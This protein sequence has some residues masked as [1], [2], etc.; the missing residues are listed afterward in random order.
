MGCCTCEPPEKQTLA[1]ITPYEKRSCTDVLLL[2]LFIGFWI[3]TV[4][5][6][7]AAIANGGNPNRVVRGV[8]MYGRICGVS[9]GVKD[10]KYAAWP[11]PDE[12]EPKICVASCAETKT[13]NNIAFKHNSISFLYYCVPSLDGSVS[14]SV[15][16]DFASA[17]ERLTRAIG[18]CYTAWKVILGS[19]FLAIGLAFMYLV[20]VRLFSGIL[21]WSAIF[22]VIIGGAFLG[23][24]LLEEAKRID[25]EGVDTDRAKV[26]KAFGA[27]AIVFTVLFSL[28]VF[29]LRKRIQIAV[30]VVKEASQALGDMK[31]MILFPL[32]PLVVALAYVAAWI[33]VA[34]Y[35]YSVA[36]TVTKTTPSTVTSGTSNPSTYQF[37]ERNTSFNNSLIYHFFG[38]LWNVQFL[39]YFSYMVLA[40]AVADWYFTPKG[41]F[42]KIKKNAVAPLSSAVNA[43][44]DDNK[45]DKNV[46][47]A[48]AAAIGPVTRWPVASSLKRTLRFHLGTVA[49]GALIIAIINFIRAWV[50]YIEE[51]TKNKNNTIQKVFFCM[52]QCFLKC[53]HCCADKI[54]KNSFI[55]T[56]IWGDNFMSGA[57]GSFC[58]IWNNLARVA[59]INVVSAYLLFLGKVLVALG[60]TGISAIILVYGSEYKDDISSPILPLLIIFIISYAVSCLFMLVYDT[61]IDTIFLC[62]LVDEQYNKNGNMMASKNLQELIGKYSKESQ[63]LAVKSYEAI[64]QPQLNSP[65]KK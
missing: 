56:A 49:F 18:D 38:L 57:V 3:G 51:K 16:G 6:T 48:S 52:I 34:L 64:G 13:N 63:D 5:I 25:S 7:A 33:V 54:S 24:T 2:A 1:Q 26:L 21:V 35:I 12:Y 40:G 23:W 17:T 62:F 42:S 28:V 47:S 44:E 4:Y 31:S 29:S 8:D 30:E 37:Y 50:K 45:K 61:T 19:A 9:E 11:R 58:L 39:I 55:W 27:I 10:Q 41:A 36:S 59:A 32:I 22:G 20:L 14:I 43:W 53:L 46:A 65:V 15:S 60:T